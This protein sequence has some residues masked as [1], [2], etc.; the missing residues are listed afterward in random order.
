MHTINNSDNKH[1]THN[2]HEQILVGT[3]QVSGV[4]IKVVI[5]ITILVN[6]LI[7]QDKVQQDHGLDGI[8][9]KQ[10]AVSA[11]ALVLHHRQLQQV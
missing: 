6:G 7:Q 5:G 2:N 8:N 11:V 4:E 9:S 10:E 1:D 3:E